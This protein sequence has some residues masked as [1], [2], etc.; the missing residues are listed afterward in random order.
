MT[1]PELIAYIKNEISYGS[2]QDVIAKR[3]KMEG[4][5]DDDII[6]A[7][8]LATAKV[9][10]PAPSLVSSEESL[11]TLESKPEGEIING[12]ISAITKPALAPVRKNHV[13][14]YLVSAI[15]VIIIILAGLA[16]F[17]PELFSN[18]FNS[19]PKPEIATNN[20]GN[21][22]MPENKQVPVNNQQDDSPLVNSGDLTDGVSIQETI[23]SNGAPYVNTDISTGTSPEASEG[24][25]NIA[26]A[27][28]EPEQT[29][30]YIEDSSKQSILVNMRAAAEAYH[31]D[32]IGNNTYKGF[33][34]S[35]SDVGAY[36]LAITLPKNSVYKCN[37]SVNEWAAWVKLSDGKYW[38]N[39]YK[40]Y[41]NVSTGAPKGTSCF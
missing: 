13:T 20:N 38:C 35:K 12:A 18:I 29:K 33:C 5:V 15:V 28:N 21:P 39:D 19:Q 25:T 34:T 23:D 10:E 37:D 6:E 7:F 11:S 16:V 40:N 8:N 32:V 24:N 31:D 3:L 30:E 4:W 2:P 27:V 26:P 41:A 14:I 17:K 36:V 22:L 1:T 9:V